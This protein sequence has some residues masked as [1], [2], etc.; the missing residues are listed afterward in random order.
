MPCRKIVFI[1][2]RSANVSI[3]CQWFYRSVFRVEP[4]QLVMC[5]ST[6]L[7]QQNW[8]VWKLDMKESQ[9]TDASNFT[10]YLET[11]ETLIKEPSFNNWYILHFFIARA[12][13]KVYNTESQWK[14]TLS[15]LTF[16]NIKSKGL[17]FIEC[18]SG[19]TLSNL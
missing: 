6:S 1:T 14:S 2:L 4:E 18:L 15:L 5:D 16:F 8:C 19:M 17:Y 7:C 11:F 10:F 9:N 3:L 12:I 13:L